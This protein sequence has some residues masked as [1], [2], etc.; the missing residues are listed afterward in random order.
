MKLRN[1]FPTAI[2][3]LLTLIAGCG[4]TP[5]PPGPPVGPM[6][7]R[8]LGFGVTEGDIGY[9]LAFASAKNAGIEF[10]ELPQQWDEVEM[11]AGNFSSPFAKMANEVY[12][13]LG[14]AVVLSLNPIDTSAV[15]VPK[16]LL[17]V[18]WDSD[19][20]IN[21]FIHW[22]D[23]TKSQLPDADLVAV[24]IGNEVDAYFSIHPEEIEAYARF[25]E[26]VARHIRKQLPDTK[27][28]CKMTFPG[29]TG[30]LQDSLA[31]IDLQADAIMLTYYPLDDL[32]HVR[33]PDEIASDFDVMVGLSEKPIYLLETGYPSGAACQSSESRQAAFIDAL[34]QAWDKHVDR[35]PMVNLVWTCD[36]SKPQIDAMVQYYGIAQPAFRG[37]L[38]TL[39]LRT[40]SGIDKPAFD[41]VRENVK[42]RSH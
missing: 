2:A 41:R 22:F 16:H 34:F 30:Q 24:S 28:G 6:S 37:F 32:F 19:E 12:P 23:W 33:D 26:R 1:C 18:P 35:V 15:R 36:M 17:D 4:Q 8:Q 3:S 42:L 14:T 29:R 21:G 38:S 20:C 27:V 10:I 31:M 25:F 40:A 13:Q 9:E 11:A 5:S 39:G 7:D